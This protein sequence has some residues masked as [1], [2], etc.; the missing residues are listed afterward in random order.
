PARDASLPLEGEGQFEALF[1]ER[2]LPTDGLGY[3]VADLRGREHELGI[4]VPAGSHRPLRRASRPRRM[5]RRPTADA[6]VA[7]SSASLWTS[8]SSS[9]SRRICNTRFMRVAPSY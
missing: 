1:D 7:D 3:Q 4:P 5:S 2:A 8:S 6:E 9:G